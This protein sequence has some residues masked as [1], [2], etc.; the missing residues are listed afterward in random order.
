MEPK[1]TKLAKIVS[2]VVIGLGAILTLLL[3]IKGDEA[4]KEN[5]ND[6]NALLSLSYIALFSGIAIAV[7]SAVYG[8]LK[9]PGALKKTLMGVGF[10]VVVALLSY[11]ISSGADY[12]TYS[13]FDVTESESRLVSA[14]L[15]MFY[16]IGAIAVGAVAWSSFGR[17][18]K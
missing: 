18:L 12:I 3:L 17:V 8:I 6:T 7:F 2:A 4:I 11:A 15:N 5:P 9:N 10:I 1:I 14:G 13:N 16:I